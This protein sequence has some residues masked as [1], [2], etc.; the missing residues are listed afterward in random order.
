MGLFD[1]NFTA[2]DWGIVGAYLGLSILIGL[3]A[4]RYVGGL[5]DYLVAGGRCGSGSP[6]PP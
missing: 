4:N 2:W 6:W 1:T 3:W 5:A